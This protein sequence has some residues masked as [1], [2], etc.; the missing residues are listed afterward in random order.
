MARFLLVVLLLAAIVFGVGIYLNW[1]SLNIHHDQ[2]NADLH[3]GKEE[4]DRLGNKIDK[5]GEKVKEGAKAA[6]NSKTVKGQIRSVDPAANAFVLETP[7]QKSLEMH[8]EHTT[9][10]QE[11]NR[12]T[13]LDSS[14]VGDQ[15]TVVY[16]EKDGKNYATRV[17]LAAK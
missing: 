4:A 7:K 17:T 3:R 8:T 1:W 9:Q 16:Q 5:E 14:K 13:Q 6:A 2:I 10:I 15:A 12:A 11:G